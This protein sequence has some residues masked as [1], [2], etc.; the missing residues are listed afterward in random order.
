VSSTQ[1]TTDVVYQILGASEDGKVAQLR[2][3]KPNQTIELQNYYDALFQPTEASNA[4]F[5]LT[6]RYLVAIRVASFTNS[7]AVRD[8]YADLAAKSGV[9]PEAIARASDV[10]IPWTGDSSLA[11]AIRHTDL[12]VSRTSD[13]RRDDIEALKAAGFSP[14]GILSLSQVI[15]FVSYQL[16]LI[17]GLRAFGAES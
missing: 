9:S 3:V 1:T 16:R 13:A 7:T 5:P 10:S 15:A 2:N 11:A 14:A 4:A 6:E 12:L 8:W 17:A